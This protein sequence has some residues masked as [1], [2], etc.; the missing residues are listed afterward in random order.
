LHDIIS[1]QLWKS[2][3]LKTTHHETTTLDNERI[4]MKKIR[5]GLNNTPRLLTLICCL[6][7]APLLGGLTGCSTNTGRDE[8]NAEKRQDANTSYDVKNALSS[9]IQYKF[10]GVNVDTN[11]GTVQLSGFVVSDDQ[12]TRAGQIAKQVSSVK[13]VVNNITVKPPT[14]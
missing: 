5:A 7:A 13:L 12:K 6:G 10:E 4:E 2:Q 11:T 3:S 8:T 9:D 14:N 1:T